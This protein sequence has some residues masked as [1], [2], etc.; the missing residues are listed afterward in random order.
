MQD[1][2]S[3]ACLYL[4]QMCA[5]VCWK[6]HARKTH[7]RTH[8]HT[9]H[10]SRRPPFQ[11]CRGLSTH[12]HREFPAPRRL[13][14]LLFSTHLVCSI[15]RLFPQMSTKYLVYQ[16]LI[17]QSRLLYNEAVPPP[18]MSTQCCIYIPI[19]Y[20]CEHGHAHN[21]IHTSLVYVSHVS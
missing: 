7:A 11:K 6:T 4:C 8:K 2:S 10:K 21:T 19:S 3:I 15:R 1:L 12:V 20:I 14:A 17:C 18:Q 9:A 13:F 5:F 16:P